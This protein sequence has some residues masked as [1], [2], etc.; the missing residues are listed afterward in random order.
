MLIFMEFLKTQCD[1]NI[2]QNALNCTKFSKFSRGAS[3][4]PLDLL[5]YMY[6]QL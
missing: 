6:M 4:M 2:H 3:I 1:Q 5:V